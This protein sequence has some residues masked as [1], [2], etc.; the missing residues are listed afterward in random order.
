M[1]FH[2]SE[3]VSVVDGP[4]VT[5]KTKGI[6]EDLKKN[7]ELNSKILQKKTLIRK[8]YKCDIC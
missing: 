3:E 8:A 2:V 7:P 1:S 6:K 4:H 5:H